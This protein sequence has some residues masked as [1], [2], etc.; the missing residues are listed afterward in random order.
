MLAWRLLLLLSIVLLAE[1]WLIKLLIHWW[2]DRMLVHH[3]RMLSCAWTWRFL[4]LEIL[5]VVWLLLTQIIALIVTLARS[6]HEI[7]YLGCSSLRDPGSAANT[8]CGIRSSSWL[9]VRRVHT[10]LEITSLDLELPILGQVTHLLLLLNLLLNGIRESP[11]IINCL[12][13]SWDSLLLVLPLNGGIC[14]ARFHGTHS[15]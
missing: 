5:A 2:R 12:S 3:C 13:C 10:A 6:R 11:Q 7:V 9:I 8:G 1:G 14:L 15:L 4:R